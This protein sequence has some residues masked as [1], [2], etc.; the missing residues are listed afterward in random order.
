MLGRLVLLALYLMS[1]VRASITILYPTSDTVWYKNDTVNLNWTTT[2]PTSDLYLFRALL[3]NQDQSL[4]AGNH[5]IADSTNATADYVRILLPQLQSGPGYIVNFV[6][7]TDEEQVLASSQAFEIADGDVTT[8][9]I[10]NSATASASQSFDI[11]NAVTRSSATS[12]P[13]A[14]AS[15]SSTTSSAASSHG[16]DGL[17]G[18]LV[19]ICKAV[20]FIGVG[21]T[22]AL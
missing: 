21:M 17:R 5:S 18:M 6:N 11:P 19:H 20:A 4:L 22:L 7:T 2:T 9:T 15:T 16:M 8:S 12:N 14:T 10:S 13:F 1:S 3:S